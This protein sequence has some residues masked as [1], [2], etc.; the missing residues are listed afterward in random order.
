ME[1]LEILDGLYLLRDYY[2]CGVL[3]YVSAYDRVYGL[4]LY[5]LL[6]YS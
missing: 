6:L 3:D 5:V 1:G 2:M 4:R